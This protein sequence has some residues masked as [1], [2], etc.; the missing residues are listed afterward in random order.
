LKLHNAKEKPK[1]F[2]G[3]HMAEGTAQYAEG[4]RTEMIFVGEETIKNM[5]PTF[6]GCP[7]Y[8]Q[9]VDDVNLDKLQEQADGYVVRSFYNRIDGKHWVEFMVVSDRGHEALRNGWKLSNAYIPKEFAGGGQWH[10]M[11][12]N[13]EVK[14]ADYEHLALVQ[15]PRY[16]ESIILTPEEFK[17]YCNEKE[18][19]LKKIANSKEESKTMLS[20]FKKSKVENAADFESM[21]VVLPKCKKQI[22]IS[23]LVTNMDDMEMEQMA[24]G[25]HHVMVGEKKMKL[26]DLVKAHMDMCNEME[27]MKKNAAA[28]PEDEK[29]LAVE[30]KQVDVGGDLK[31][32]E[33]EAAL[34]KAKDDEKDAEVK[35]NELKKEEGKK[36][37]DALKNADKGDKNPLPQIELTGNQ[38]A[39]GK[40]RYGS[41]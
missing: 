33:D 6:Q 26:N 35:K 41:N 4:G 32:E 37:F 16:A 21:Y 17:S 30:E 10:G 7:V 34:K 3:L 27:E 9:H 31:N 18:L 25:D 2:F 12:Y 23:E 29:E 22:T 20:L 8:V 19:E 40:S 28:K 14:R 36:H 11:D 1:L 15:N 38:I 5:D 13:R 24:N 39:R